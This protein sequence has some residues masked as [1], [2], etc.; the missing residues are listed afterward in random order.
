MPVAPRILLAIL[1]IFS[2]WSPALSQGT[3][4]PR[5]TP[6][7]GPAQDFQSLKRYLASVYKPQV[8]FLDEFREH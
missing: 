3:R 5:L 7:S 4:I 2:S 8:M 1:L 6:P